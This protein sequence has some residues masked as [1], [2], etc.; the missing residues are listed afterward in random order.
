MKVKFRD[1]NGELVYM[2]HISSL[3]KERSRLCKTFVLYPEAVSLSYGRYDYTASDIYAGRKG[4]LRQV[5]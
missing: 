3:K 1:I 5:A 2:L 4:T